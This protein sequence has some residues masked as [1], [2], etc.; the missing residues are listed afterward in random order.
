MRRS[1]MHRSLKVNHTQRS[2][3]AMPAF[4]TPPP[5]E[6]GAALIP[7]YLRESRGRAPG[8][9]LGAATAAI[10]YHVAYWVSGLV[11]NQLY[12]KLG[13]AEQLGAPPR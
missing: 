1:E 11:G 4:V 13:Q 10:A 7:L 8:T 6:H 12:F 3:H 2:P 9:A 5:R